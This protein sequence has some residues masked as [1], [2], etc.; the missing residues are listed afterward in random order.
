MPD[1]ANQHHDAR[2]VKPASGCRF[3]L[4]SILFVNVH[5]PR[6]N[7]NSTSF[8]AFLVQKE[9]KIGNRSMKRKRAGNLFS[10]EDIEL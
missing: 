5:P 3:G 9:K 1:C 2:L 8:G 4:T 6:N 10:D 7:K